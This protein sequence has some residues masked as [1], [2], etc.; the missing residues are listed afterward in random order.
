MLKLKDV[1]AELH[2]PQKALAQEIDLSAASVAQLVNHNQWPKSMSAES[3]KEKV[4]G[5]LQKRGASQ[6]AIDTAFEVAG[7]AR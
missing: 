5:F 7:A 4:Q 1:L 2:V 3:I 6:E